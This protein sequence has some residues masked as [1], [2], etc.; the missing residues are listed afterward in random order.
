M[1]LSDEQRE[2]DLA[3][4]IQNGWS[5]VPD[6]DAISK[7]FTFKSFIE[8]FG[9]MTRIAIWSEKYRHHPEWSNVYNKVDVTLTTHD[10][11]GLTE[12][13]VKLANKMDTL[14]H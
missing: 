1:K 6:R 8:A 10:S 2:S 13:D 3:P 12:L 14:A 11:D 7:T 9:W 4:L 5:L